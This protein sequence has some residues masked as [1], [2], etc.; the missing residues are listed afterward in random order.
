MRI[1]IAVIT[2]NMPRPQVRRRPVHQVD[3]APAAALVAG[4]SGPVTWVG[5]GLFSK[6]GEGSPWVFMASK[7]LYWRTKTRAC[8][9]GRCFRLDGRDPLFDANLPE[10]P[11]QPALNKFFR[12]VVNEN[13]R[14]I[15]RNLILPRK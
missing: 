3:V 13:G 7:R 6:T 8:Y 1:P 4:V 5:K 11:P 15:G 2:K 14:A 9:D 10:L 12:K